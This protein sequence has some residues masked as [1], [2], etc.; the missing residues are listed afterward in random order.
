MD[1]QNKH[2]PTEQEIKAAETNYLAMLNELEQKYG[3]DIAHILAFHVTTSMCPADKQEDIHTQI[4]PSFLT[5]V[6][7]RLSLNVDQLTE[8]MA[9]INKK[10][11]EYNLVEAA[12]DGQEQT[13]A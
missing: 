10:L 8:A 7:N 3:K 5:W 2:E 9:F 6:S 4:I 12:N 11:S 1:T 13:A